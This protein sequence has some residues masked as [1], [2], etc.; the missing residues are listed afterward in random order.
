MPELT[1]PKHDMPVFGGE[2]RQ[3][4]LRNAVASIQQRF[5]VSLIRLMAEDSE[6]RVVWRRIRARL[7]V[8]V[9]QWESLA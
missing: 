1:P 3:G 2:Q 4:V 8:R 9:K 6:R 7:R 5:A